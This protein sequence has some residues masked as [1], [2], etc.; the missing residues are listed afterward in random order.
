MSFFAEFALKEYKLQINTTAGGKVMQ[1]VAGEKENEYMLV[2]P[3]TSFKHGQS[4]NIAIVLIPDEG[5]E[6][7]CTINGQPAYFEKY[8]EN[9]IKT[10]PGIDGDVT[11]DIQFYRLLSAEKLLAPA[12][13]PNPV[14][15]QLQ[16][17]NLVVGGIIELRSLSGVVVK[18]ATAK[19]EVH[20]LDCSALPAGVY[21]LRIDGKMIQKI[22]KQ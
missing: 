1:R 2:K 4:Q 10:L 3:A 11:I 7:H 13:Y 15:D 21:L 14:R 19:S 12:V 17:R 20:T 16:L 9:W 8:K 6:I 18:Q 5:Y 22:F